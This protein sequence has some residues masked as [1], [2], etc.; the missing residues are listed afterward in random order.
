MLFFQVL[1]LVELEIRELLTDYGFDGENSPIIFGSA[2]CALNDKNPNVGENSIRK[3]LDA[4]DEYLP[5]PQR[6]ISSPFLLP[7]DNA[8]HVPGRGTVVVGT[9]TRGTIKRN[10]EAELLGFDSQIKTS[11]SDVQVFKK[12]VPQAFAGDNIGVL[13]RTIKLKDIEKGMLLCAYGSE[14]IS[15][16]FQAS[17]YFL[18]KSEGGR[19]RPILTKYTQQLFSKTW[20]IQC[21][22]DLGNLREISIL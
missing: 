11:V 3:L 4:I 2:L 15:N 22:V 17:I 8:F 10:N 14:K 19:S 7:I 16:R 5:D 9:L 1:D 18:T 20:S 21:R 13:L 6:D 12:S